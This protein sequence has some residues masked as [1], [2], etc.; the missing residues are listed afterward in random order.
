[1]E[2]IER[3]ERMQG[4][5]E[6]ELDDSEDLN[7]YMKEEGEPDAPPVNQNPVP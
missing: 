4:V 3:E 6:P 5:E 7:K 2:E 1:M